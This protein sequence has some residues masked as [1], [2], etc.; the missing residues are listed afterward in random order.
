MISTALREVTIWFYSNLSQLLRKA[1]ISAIIITIG[2]L[3]AK[4]TEMVVKRILRRL[5]LNKWLEEKKIRS[6]LFNI[7][8]EKNA[9]QVIKWYVILIFFGE[10]A[11][12]A[13]MQSVASAFS[14]LLVLIPNWAVG[15]G[16]LAVFLVIADKIR[17]RVKST[18]VIFSS[19]VGDLS[20]GLILFFGLVLALPKFGFK[21]I[22][23]LVDSFKILVGG[24]AAGLALAI[25]IGFGT[26]I[27]EGPAKD[28]F[29]EE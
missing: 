27:K 22:D 15:A 8:L 3:V 9:A 5:E 6:S 12:K 21:N 13:G 18:G 16:I 28:L 23:V 1:I 2:Y 10:A 14:R 19:I 11:S 26:A 29:K 24:F 7:D 20:Y 25:G 17:E 4:I